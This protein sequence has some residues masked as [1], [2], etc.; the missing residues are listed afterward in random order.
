MKWVTVKKIHINTNNV[1]G[2]KW[3]GGKLYVFFNSDTD[4]AEWD[5]PDRDLYLK[6]CRQQGIRPVDALED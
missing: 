2:F 3:E 1:D 6:L 5:D 4:P